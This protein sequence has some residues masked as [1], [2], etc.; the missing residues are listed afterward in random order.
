MQKYII[1]YLLAA[2][3]PT[4]SYSQNLADGITIYDTRDI[5]DLPN[6]AKKTLRVDF[7]RRSAIGVPGKGEYSANITLAPWGDA[8][9]NL[10]HQLNF[11]DGSI[12]YRTGNFS[13]STWNAWQKILLADAA[14]NIDSNLRIGRIGNAG[15]INVPLGNITNQYSI[16][17]TG[18]RDVTTDQIGARI[19]A[20][21]YNIHQ[22]DKA[23]IQNTALAF[24]TNASGLNPG[25]TDLQERMR[26]SPGGYIGIGTINPQTKLD[27]RGVISATEVKVQILTG[28]DHVFG[29]SYDLRPLSEVERFVQEN[30]HLP[31]IP[32]E[33]QMQEE[34]LS[35]NE[36]QIKLLQKIEELTL[37][38]IELKKEIDQLKAQNKN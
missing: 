26:I 1:L 34:G 22:A 21:R 38:T 7:K 18:Y 30:K 2:L 33:K 17:F 19:A 14:G 23:Y 9:G 35:I 15:N 28:A 4:I 36:F 3:I 8:S 32:S 37:Y 20:I 5:N 16:D 6:F 27:V 31:E 10:N 11:N 12:Y 29:E 24:Y 25:T 13:N